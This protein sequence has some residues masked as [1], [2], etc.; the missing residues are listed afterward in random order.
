MKMETHGHG[1]LPEKTLARTSVE[2]GPPLPDR[3]SAKDALP[4]HTLPRGSCTSLS[5]G[6]SAKDAHPPLPRGSSAAPVSGN[7][8]TL[9]RYN[10]F[11][12]MGA[13]DRLS[14]RLSNLSALSRTTRETTLANMPTTMRRE[15]GLAPRDSSASV[16]HSSTRT[17]ASKMDE[18]SAACA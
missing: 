17:S 10:S 1:H 2:R 18:A 6:S 11:F 5:G 8:S 12:S 13:L 9:K 3:N 16:R 4:P 14:T 15:L 7:F